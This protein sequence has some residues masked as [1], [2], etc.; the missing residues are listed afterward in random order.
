MSYFKSLNRL[1][2]IFIAFFSLG[3]LATLVVFRHFTTALLWA[4]SLCLFLLQSRNHNRPT[5]IL[6][7]AFQLFKHPVLVTALIFALLSLVSSLWAYT[8]SLAF[9]TGLTA[10]AT[11]GLF[12]LFY[13]QLQ[14]ISQTTMTFL[15][16]LLL[17]I[18][19]VA[20]LLVAA[21]VYF[22][23][24][25]RFVLGLDPKLLKTNTALLIV[26]LIPVCAG[27]S[28]TLQRPYFHQAALIIGLYLLC[29]HQ[30]YQAAKA[31]LLLGLIVA[32]LSLLLPRFIA[33]MT[34]FIP[35]ILCVTMPLLLHFFMQ[36]HSPES[37]LKISKLSSFAHRLHVWRFINQTIKSKLYLGWGANAGRALPG[38]DIELY[39]G[40]D[41]MPSHPHNH[42]MQT[43]LELGLVGALVLAL[44]HYFLF[45]EI[46]KIKDKTLKFWA[47]FYSMACF[48]IFLISHSLWHKWWLTAFGC[49]TALLMR[50]VK[51]PK[52]T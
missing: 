22:Q 19:I 50:L 44:L 45:Q 15:I 17:G 27:L 7:Q 48:C 24:P 43:W 37:L 32:S 23:L 13:T 1:E 33:T 34:R 51:G 42:I 39:S 52:S 10:I 31:G 28:K 4:T 3:L 6:M 16:K 38:T 11:L 5:Q 9:K 47:L 2:Q 36:F 21:Q 29:E 25:F 40:A 41:A 18:S 30:G 49:A 26:L 35:T 8:P 46:A 20:L 12:A 14:F